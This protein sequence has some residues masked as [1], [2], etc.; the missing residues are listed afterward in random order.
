MNN[1][2]KC[3]DGKEKKDM[4][5]NGCDFSCDGNINTDPLGSYTGVPEEEN[6][7]PVQDVDDL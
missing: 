6:E 1:H 4:S 3:A 2:N 5:H 7:K